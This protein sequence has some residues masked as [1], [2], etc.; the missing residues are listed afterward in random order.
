M[1]TKG[2]KGVEQEV[3]GGHRQAGVAHEAAKLDGEEGELCVGSDEEGKGV[4]ECS[5][6]RQAAA[7]TV[8]ARAPAAGRRQSLSQPALA[9]QQEAE[10]AGRDIVQRGHRVQLQ[11]ARLHGW[12]E[13]VWGGAGKR[14]CVCSC[15]ISRRAAWASVSPAPLPHSRRRLACSRICTMTRRMLSLKMLL[16]WNMTPTM[17]KLSS[18]AGGQAGR[19]EERSTRSRA[20]ACVPRCCRQHDPLNGPAPQQSPRTPAS[21]ELTEG[22]DGDAQRDQPHVG[23]RRPAEAVGAKEA[24]HG[25]DGHGHERLL[26]R[27]G[28]RGE[29]RV[30]GRAGMQAVGKRVG[31]GRHAPGTQPARDPGEQASTSKH[32]RAATSHTT[33]RQ[34]LSP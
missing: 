24:T 19:G 3:N 28:E 11:A 16:S 14:G 13:R 30:G 7:A 21:A 15:S 17:L 8:S 2:G 22:R 5:R 1:R 29:W 18:P 9:H 34:E 25:E 31:N 10:A 26:R 32:A 6:G 33:S 23:H 12:R 4:D 20:A 27:V